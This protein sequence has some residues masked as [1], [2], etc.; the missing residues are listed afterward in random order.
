L[1]WRFGNSDGRLEFINLEGPK[2]KVPVDPETL[3]AVVCID[4][5]G[6][7]NSAG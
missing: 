1:V 7:E 5:C 4:G 6:V 2:G 3:D